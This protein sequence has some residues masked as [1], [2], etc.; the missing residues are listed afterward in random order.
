MTEE[1][2]TTENKYT[3]EGV[4]LLENALIEIDRSLFKGKEK[5][6]KVKLPDENSTEDYYYTYV[7]F[8]KISDHLIENANLVNH[9]NNA[10]YLIEF[11]NNYSLEF[12]QAVDKTESKLNVKLINRSLDSLAT[13]YKDILT[14]H[15]FLF[16]LIY[17]YKLKKADNFFAYLESVLRELKV[18]FDYQNEL[19]K[20][21]NEILR[22][23]GGKEKIGFFS[24]EVTVKKD[25]GD[26]FD[27]AKDINFTSKPYF[28]VANI[29]F[30]KLDFNFYLE[31]KYEE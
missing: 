29:Y 7:A 28:D 26:I 16:S 13:T 17:I 21:I 27:L 20:E 9:W 6:K 30:N 19:S 23:D 31:G 1:N 11:I 10:T 4:K 25:G 12:I 8:K 3:K 15:F 14:F 5:L 2:K 22:A 24:K 18:G